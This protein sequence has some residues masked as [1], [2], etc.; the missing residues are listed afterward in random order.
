MKYKLDKIWVE[1][2]ARLDSLEK[3]L[4]LIESKSKA[5]TKSKPKSKS[6]K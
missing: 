5:G 3:R 4:D 1:T 2:K 6:K